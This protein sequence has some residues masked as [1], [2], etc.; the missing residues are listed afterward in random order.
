[1]DAEAK[2]D[3]NLIE[4][5]EWEANML[6]EDLCKSLLLLASYMLRGGGSRAIILG[7]PRGAIHPETA[8]TL[9]QENNIGNDARYI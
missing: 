9:Y 8:L 7:R 2:H 5:I 1:M 6:A 4:S 3:I